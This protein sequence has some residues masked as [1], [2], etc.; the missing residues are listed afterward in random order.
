ME[1]IENSYAFHHLINMQY[2]GIVQ[3]E[4]ENMLPAIRN[5]YIKIR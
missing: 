4:L 1:I 3:T 2:P 5:P